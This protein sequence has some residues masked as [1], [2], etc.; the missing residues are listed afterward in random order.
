M[1]ENDIDAYITGEASYHDMLFAKDN[2]MSVISAGHYETEK[3]A[4]EALKERIKERFEDIEI[5]PVVENGP[6]IYF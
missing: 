4:I 5:L 2:G 1:I 3:P 6:I